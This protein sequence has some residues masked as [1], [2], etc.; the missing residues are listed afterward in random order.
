[1]RGTLINESNIKFFENALDDETRKRSDI[2]I[3][4]IDEESGNACGIL[5]AEAVGEHVLDIRYIFV[6]ENFRER[7]AGKELVYT[8]IEAAKRMQAS[9]ITCVHSRGNISDGISELLE[10]C[11]FYPDEELSSFIYG[12]MLSEIQIDEIKEKTLKFSVKSL[13]NISDK[14]WNDSRIMWDHDGGS[15]HGMAGLSYKKDTYDQELSFMAFDDNGD[16]KGM[17]LGKIS[18]AGFEILTLSAIGAQKSYILYALLKNAI[19]TSRKKL[20]EQTYVIVSGASKSSM[21]VLDHISGGAYI[22]LG[23]TIYYYYDIG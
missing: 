23:K 7:G 12:A 11:G 4:V 19:D 20:D 14:K 18:E 5:A 9:G 17:I 3:G 16:I 6:D 21:E 13:K 15:S 2:L 1:M 22:T 8:F 10:S